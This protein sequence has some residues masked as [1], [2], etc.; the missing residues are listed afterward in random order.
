MS[1]PSQCGR[2]DQCVVMGPGAVGLMCFDAHR[3]HLRR[4][5]LPPA[6]ATT[7]ASV[8]HQNGFYFV[9]VDLKASKNTVVILR[10]LN[11]CFPHPANDTQ[12]CNILCSFVCIVDFRPVKKQ[13]SSVIHTD[14]VSTTGL[15]I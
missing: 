10:E 2:M 6:P 15:D 13:M 8:N 14:F 1:T 9:I 4:L 12:V 5:A 3:C 11:A 7:E